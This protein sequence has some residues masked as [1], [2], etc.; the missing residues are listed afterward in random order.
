MKAHHTPDYFPVSPEAKW[1]PELKALRERFKANLFDAYFPFWDQTG[2]DHERG[3][4]FCWLNENGERVSEEKYMWY[5]GR[6]LWVYSHAHAVFGENPAFLEI[7]RKTYRFLLE[8]GRDNEGY[9]L[10][11]VGPNGEAVSERDGMGYAGMFVAEGMQEYARASGDEEA[12]KHAIE[13][14]ERSVSLFDDPGRNAKP[15]DLKYFYPGIRL[16]GHE[17]VKIRFLKQLLHQADRTEYRETLREAVRHVFEDFYRP[18]LGLT[19]EALDHDYNY[20]DD[21]NRKFCILGHSMETFWMIMDAASLLGDEAMFNTAEERFRSHHEAAWD[22]DRKMYRTLVDLDAG[23]V[24]GQ[25]IWHYDEAIIGFLMIAIARGSG[26]ARD[27]ALKIEARAESIFKIRGRRGTV[28]A[29]DAD[30]EGKLRLPI[31]RIGNYHTARRWM[32]GLEFLARLAP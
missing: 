5:Q 14:Y 3:G 29:R 30:D 22:H 6:G 31:S 23:P 12:L 20:R 25:V 26:S 15:E 8:H 1:T 18:E 4:F 11:S 10:A 2:V 16:L 24:E 17:M 21:P 9:W 32:L 7:A 28:W 27:W 13:A 19:V